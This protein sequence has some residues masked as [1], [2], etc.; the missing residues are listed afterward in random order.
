MAEEVLC[1]DSESIDSLD[2]VTL[3]QKFITQAAE[4]SY[5][6]AKCVEM[7]N[8]IASFNRSRTSSAYVA[9]QIIL[10]YFTDRMKSEDFVLPSYSRFFIVS[11][12]NSNDVYPLPDSF[13]FSMQNL[14]LERDT[15]FDVIVNGKMLHVTLD[16]GYLED[17][18]PR[19][20]CKDEGGKTY[21]AHHI[22]NMKKPKTFTYK[23]TDDMNLP[24]CDD[25]VKDDKR[26]IYISNDTKL[27]ELIK[28]YLQPD[29]SDEVSSTMIVDVKAFNEWK[30][31]LE[32]KNITYFKLCIFGTLQKTFIARA[33]DDKD[34]LSATYNLGFCRIW[35]YSQYTKF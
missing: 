9:V 24:S 4:L 16:T 18:L 6:K 29:T 23:F 12:D 8:Q 25:D 26:I 11:D 10:E 19:V 31:T 15:S 2:Q 28:F 27:N 20:V 34:R 13:G 32:T 17:G 30:T 14:V 21:T 22:N 7:Q 1:K 3:K 35:K 33:Y 5:Y